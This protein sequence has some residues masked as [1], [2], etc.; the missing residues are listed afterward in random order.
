M[1]PQDSNQRVQRERSSLINQVAS[2]SFNLESALNA[3]APARLAESERYA[4]PA[5]HPMAIR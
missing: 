4:L 1:S 2:G 3:S 5:N